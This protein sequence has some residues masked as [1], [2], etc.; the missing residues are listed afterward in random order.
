MK[1]VLFF[2]S[3]IFFI[4]SGAQANQ[5]KLYSVL[6]EEDGNSILL[7]LTVPLLSPAIT[8]LNTNYSS[9]RPFQS[10]ESKA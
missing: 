5:A 3:C 2:L 6:F 7:L 8:I 4:V 1:L 10:I 9:I